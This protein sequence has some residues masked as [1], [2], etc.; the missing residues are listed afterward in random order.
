MRDVHPSLGTAVSLFLGF[1][2]LQ[3]SQDCGVT[4]PRC[5]ESELHSLPVP[6]HS[7]DRA[8][9]V[10][11]RSASPCHAPQ[12]IRSG[13]KPEPVGQWV[14]IKA[15]LP[16]AH[17]SAHTETARVHHSMAPRLL[18]L[19]TPAA[20]RKQSVRVRKMEMFLFQ[21]EGDTRPYLRQSTQAMPTP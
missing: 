10:V 14:Y 6:P 17:I 4:C 9:L 11:S 13:N 5:P 15:L 7:S 20:P 16:Q 8:C 2:H 21:A 18:P 19:H 12:R 3:M 1:H